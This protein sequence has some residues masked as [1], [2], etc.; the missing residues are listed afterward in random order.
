MF[1]S[2][3]SGT[4]FCVT[5]LFASIAGANPNQ[6]S[7]D[8]ALDLSKFAKSDEILKQAKGL[9]DSCAKTI[10]NLA[11][12]GAKLPSQLVA[13][14]Q[15]RRLALDLQMCG[16]TAGFDYGLRE[17]WLNAQ[18]KR[19]IAR[20]KTTTAGATQAAKDRQFL[21]A[22]GTTQFRAVALEKIKQLAQQQKWPAAYAM[23]NDTLDKLSSYT[24]FLEPAE[25]T[26]YLLQFSEVGIL[27]TT[28][29][30]AIFRQQVQE[31]L[32]QLVTAQLPNPQGLVTA[33]SAAATGLRTASSVDV[34]GKLLNGPQC[35]EYFGNSWRQTQL[36]ALRCRAIEWAR[37]VSVPAYAH[38]LP[39]IPGANR[40]VDADY[41]RLADDVI[42]AL[43]SLIAA[44]A[45]RVAGPDV[46]VLYGAYLQAAAP[47]VS[48]TADDKLRLAL[49]PAL[50]TLA[51]KTPAFGAEVAAYRAATDECLR[52]R[53]RV[54]KCAADARQKPFVPSSQLLLQATA[55]K[56]GYQGLLA[57]SEPKL[58]EAQLLSSCPEVLLGAAP[59][60]VG[61]KMLIQHTVGL[62]EGKFCVSRYQQRHYAMLPR[63]DVAQE[64]QKLRQ[65][66]LISELGPPL[67]LD[68]AVAVTS[69]QQGDYVLVGGEVK[70][71]Y[72]EGLIPR[73]AKLPEAAAPIIALGTM[74]SEPP[75]E[76]LLSH[77]LVRLSITPSW[78]NHRYFFVE[79]SQPTVPA[80]TN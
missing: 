43:A 31:I 48:A 52:W 38:Y 57:L 72:L 59:K 67:T 24:M 25:E 66:L 9:L 13:L 62:P 12:Q 65:D 47:L 53:E 55:S 28:K 60:L 3:I 36:A 68:A 1:R 5:L 76:R 71:I 6:D 8:A 17:A 18:L 58:G 80:S 21:S 7:P 20:F 16:E 42:K 75:A 69:A 39:Q 34:G 40:I 22:P 51:A 74:P 63:P 46:V 70:S 15:L 11:Q 50:E 44:D 41:G 61:Q 73:F 4:V 29:R 78:V 45:A 2:A 49:T 56:E 79:L 23:L 14:R 54:A 32:D 10:P 77:V 33:V 27:V 37:R 35:L 26:P 19:A 64:I 30:N